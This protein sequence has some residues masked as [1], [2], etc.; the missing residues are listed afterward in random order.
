MREN[1]CGRKITSQSKIVVKCDNIRNLRS[2]SC[3]QSKLSY[4]AP[5]SLLARLL[6]SRQAVAIATTSTNRLQVLEP[7]RQLSNQTLSQRPV[8]QACQTNLHVQGMLQARHDV[9]QEFRHQMPP[10]EKKGNVLVV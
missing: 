10:H 5:G 6:A 3:R 7:A 4:R 2:R 8:K 1:N 9:I